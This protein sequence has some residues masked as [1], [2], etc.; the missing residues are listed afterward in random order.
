MR[1]RTSRSLS[2]VTI[3]LIS[4]AA[5]L[6]AEAVVLHALD[7][8]T[9]S[10]ADFGATAYGDGDYGN[11]IAET[12]PAT[13]TTAPPATTTTTQ[14]PTTSTTTIANQTATTTAAEPITS[15]TSTTITAPVTEA[16]TPAAHTP[17]PKSTAPSKARWVL[18]PLGTLVRD[19]ED[20]LPA[21]FANPYVRAAE[22]LGY[23]W[24]PIAIGC[25]TWLYL[26]YQ[27]RIDAADPKLTEAPLYEDEPPR[28]E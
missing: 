17:A 10:S 11:G 9:S 14:A 26:R 3:I 6:P 25:T 20:A 15:T 16:E 8:T 18:N 23:A 21:W 2:L 28:F 5:G 19:H 27:H 24:L 12:A 13:T 1:R 22:A 7:A 4:C